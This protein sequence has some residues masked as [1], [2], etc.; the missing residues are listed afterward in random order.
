MEDTCRKQGFQPSGYD[1][2]H[3]NRILDLTTTIRFSNLPNKATV[4][5]VEVDKKREESNV[6]VGLLLE[7]GKETLCKHYLNYLIRY[8]TSKQTIS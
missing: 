4:E 7:D 8:H 1:L 6:T 2:K 3:H 5:M